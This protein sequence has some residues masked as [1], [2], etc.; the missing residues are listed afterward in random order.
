MLLS[1]Q[2]NRLLSSPI[3]TAPLRR[4]KRSVIP[5]YEARILRAL[6]WMAHICDR[7][8]R[9]AKDRE[10][11]P[12]NKKLYRRQLDEELAYNILR[13]QVSLLKFGLFHLIRYHMFRAKFGLLYA[14]TF[15]SF[16]QQPLIPHIEEFRSLLGKLPSLLQEQIN[17]PKVPRYTWGN[18]Q[19]SRGEIES[20]KRELV[21]NIGILLDRIG[22]EIHKLSAPPIQ[23]E[24]LD[25]YRQEVKTTFPRSIALISFPTFKADLPE[26]LNLFA[27]Q[28]PAPSATG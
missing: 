14:S 24:D 9:T 4:I 13:H 26:R 10:R 25:A 11:N 3:Q 20:D 2:V 23:E 21:R 18:H 22:K 1:E 19:A 28:F 27:A 15:T 5:V 8:R 6:Y 17:A 16:G 7:L 12:N